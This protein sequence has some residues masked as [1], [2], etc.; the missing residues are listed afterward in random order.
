MP[1]EPS[2]ALLALFPLSV[3]YGE[4]SM[5]PRRTEVCERPSCGLRVL[6]LALQYS[7]LPDGITQHEK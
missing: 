7:R 4:I 3:L 5:D 1:C 6:L 2:L